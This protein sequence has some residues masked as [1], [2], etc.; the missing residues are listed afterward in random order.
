MT[1]EIYLEDSYAQKFES[2]V[3][4][5]NGRFIVLDRTAFYPQGGGQPSDKGTLKSQDGELYEVNFVNKMGNKI[6]HEVDKEGLNEGQI[7]H[8]EIDWNRRHRFMRYHTAAHILSA[9]VHKNTNALITGNQISETKARIDFNLENFDREKI[10]DYINEANHIIDK[11]L[12]VNVE[13]MSREKAFE[14]PSI[15]K[16]KKFIPEAIKEIRVVSIEGI[17]QQACAGTHVSNT[18]EIGSIELI[19]AENKGKDNR[20]I[21]FLLSEPRYHL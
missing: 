13:L 9:I 2:K 12:P 18:K 21:Y 17:D 7:V 14:I 15:V 19:N 10:D 8:G 11:H 4:E 20:R 1:E 16:L 6:M 3:K 5:V